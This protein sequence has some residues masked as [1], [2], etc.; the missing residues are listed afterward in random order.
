MS[1][2]RLYPSYKATSEQYET[3]ADSFLAA[4][5]KVCVIVTG[6]TC[7]NAELNHSCKAASEQLKTCADLFL[8]ADNKV[9]VIRTKQS[10]M[11][12]VHVKEKGSPAILLPNYAPSNHPQTTANINKS[13]NLVTRKVSN[14]ICIF[15][16][17]ISSWLSM[18]KVNHL[19]FPNIIS[20]TCQDIY[21]LTENQQENKTDHMNTSMH[22]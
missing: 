3:F 11:H 21:D 16:V 6:Q 13:N 2:A 22:T 20:I 9:C 14:K 7:N 5:T 8:T 19:V 1:N 12:I 4:N 17:T 10:C 15:N 18:C